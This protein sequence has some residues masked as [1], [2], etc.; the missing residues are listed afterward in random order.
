[1]DLE[2]CRKDAKRLARAFAAGDRQADARAHGVLGT[3]ASERFRL[4]DAQHV[5]AVERGYRSWPEMV[6]ALRAREPEPGEPR[7]DGLTETGLEYRPGEPVLVHVVRRDRRLSVT[8][9]GAAIAQAGA[10]AGWQAVA[11][12]LGRESAVNVSRHGVVSLPVVPVGP[13]LDAIVQRIADASL[14]FYQE[15]LELRS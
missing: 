15:L 9:G 2:Q 7:T 13:G 1:M 10:A 4:S 11:E 5:V 8:D 6:R 3:R 14:A 12:R